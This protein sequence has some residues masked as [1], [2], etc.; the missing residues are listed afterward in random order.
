MQY[1]ESVINFTRYHMPWH[2]RRNSWSRISLRRGEFHAILNSCKSL[3]SK[4]MLYTTQSQL[5]SQ[6]WPAHDFF[7]PDLVL[8]MIWS[9]GMVRTDTYFLL[10]FPTFC[11]QVPSPQTKWAQIKKSQNLKNSWEPGSGIL[12]S[13]KGDSEA[14]R[15]YTVV[16]H[17]ID[18]GRSDSCTVTYSVL[19]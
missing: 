19:E 1:S 13:N 6:N 7:F 12:D 5:F 9:T 15:Y 17:M 11:L 3:G 2:G 8:E 10:I 16:C 18:R 14:R 4:M